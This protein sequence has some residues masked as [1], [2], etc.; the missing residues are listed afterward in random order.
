MKEYDICSCCRY[1]K[2]NTKQHFNF[3]EDTKVCD[4][5]YKAMRIAERD[6]FHDENSS[7]DEI[8]KMLDFIE[9]SRYLE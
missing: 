8:F 7:A 9:V 3:K 6:F 1:K 2:A 4:D 5:C